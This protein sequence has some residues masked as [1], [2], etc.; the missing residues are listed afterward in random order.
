M[1]LPDTAEALRAL[2][3]EEAPNTGSLA[4]NLCVDPMPDDERLRAAA[5]R[6]GDP[7]APAYVV[8]VTGST[9]IGIY[10]EDDVASFARKAGETILNALAHEAMRH[11][12]GE[13]IDAQV[14]VDALLHFAGSPY[15]EQVARSL[16][17]VARVASLVAARIDPEDAP[18]ASFVPVTIIAA[19]GA[20]HDVD[21]TTATSIERNDNG[22]RPT[23]FGIVSQADHGLRIT[24]ASTAAE[25]A[26]ARA[27][28]RTRFITP[29]GFSSRDAAYAAAMLEQAVI[30]GPE[31]E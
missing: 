28:D 19:A 6:D 1:G 8:R 26:E 17:D 22:Q 18:D 13:L 9:A 25:V 12:Y 23:Y 29:A 20:A 16:R 2:I 10:G 7:S 14:L 31:S 15:P 3:I 27:S 21:S 4:A 30:V 5:L 11:V 24:V